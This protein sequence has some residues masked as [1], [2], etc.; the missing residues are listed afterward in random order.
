MGQR[1]KSAICV[2]SVNFLDMIKSASASR[3]PSKL[4]LPVFF[5]FYVGQTGDL[6]TRFETHHKQSCFDRH[7]A[8][9]ICIYEEQL[10]RTR[11]VIEQDLIDNYHPV[12]NDKD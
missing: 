12:C 4:E 9:R 7:G 1:Y 10:E 8:N 6:S 11:L 2:L 3:S 5:R